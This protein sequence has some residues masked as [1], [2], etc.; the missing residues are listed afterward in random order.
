MGA[1]IPKV[2]P[3]AQHR[4]CIWHILQKVPEKLGAVYR[5]DPSFKKDFNYCLYETDTV[6]EF[7]SVWG[8]LVRKYELEEYDWLCYMYRIRDKWLP[9]FFKD[10][11]FAGMSTTQCNESMNKL[12]DR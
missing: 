12:F 10:T 4:L 6:E 3:N 7:E 5:K 11:F 8:S 1:A 2:F 9:I